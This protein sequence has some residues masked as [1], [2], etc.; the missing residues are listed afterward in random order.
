MCVDPSLK[1]LQ[2]SDKHNESE[3]YKKGNFN[4]DCLVTSYLVTSIFFSF[5]SLLTGVTI[6]YSHYA[7]N[8]AVDMQ[9]TFFSF[10]IKDLFCISH[11][12]IHFTHRGSG[13]NLYFVKPRPESLQSDLRRSIDLPSRNSDTA[14]LN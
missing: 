4:Q 7:K 11:K 14:S 2:Y 12:S 3:W 1:T 8:E 9:S 10:D 6:C 13:Q 5:Q